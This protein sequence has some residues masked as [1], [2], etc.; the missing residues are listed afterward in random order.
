MN[1]LLFKGIFQHAN[2]RILIHFEENTYVFSKCIMSKSHHERMKTRKPKY[3]DSD[4]QTNKKNR[5]Q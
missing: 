5:N 4:S 2:P 3:L 1:L